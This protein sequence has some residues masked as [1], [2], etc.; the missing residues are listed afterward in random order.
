MQHNYSFLKKF[1]LSII[2][3]SV[4]GALLVGYVA[5]AVF[6]EPIASP[7]GGNIPAPLNSG[8]IAQEKIG[9]LILNTSGGATLNGLVIFSGYLRLALTSGVPDAADCN[10]SFE[11]GRMKVDSAAKLLYICVASGWGSK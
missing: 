9:G 3:G 1:S 11:Y 7:P 5:V 6:Q 8:S 2:L 10:D 4:L